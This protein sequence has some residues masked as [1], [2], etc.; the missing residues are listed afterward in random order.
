MAGDGGAMD[1]DGRRRTAM[2]GT[3]RDEDAA[4]GASA[5][6]RTEAAPPRTEAA[7]P[8]RNASR[9]PHCAAP[10]AIVIGPGSPMIAAELDPAGEVVVLLG[11]RAAVTR[12]FAEAGIADARLVEPR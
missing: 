6:R 3:E 7:P 8:R 1:G 11:E 10:P 2:D 9:P 12:A 4:R 5:P